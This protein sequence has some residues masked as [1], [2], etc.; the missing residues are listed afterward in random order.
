[1][2]TGIYLLNMSVSGIKNLEKEIRIDFYGKQVNKNFDPIKNKVKAIYGEN[3]TGKTAIITAVDIV[4]QF[5]INENYLRDSQKQALLTEL[6]NKKTK[7]FYFRCE[8]VV[9]FDTLNIYEYEVGFSFDEKGTVF[10]AS[11]SLKYKTNNSKNASTT[12]FACRQGILEET[13]T[14]DERIIDKTKNLLEKQ[15]ALYLLFS[16]NS[17][18]QESFKDKMII[19][20]PVFF[21]AMMFTYFD[22]EDEHITYYQEVLLEELK[23][24]R[25]PQE[26]LLEAISQSIPTNEEK[27]LIKNYD[28]Y[29]KT[30][31]EKEKFIRLFKPSLKKIDIIKRVDGEAYICRLVLDYGDYAVD[32]EF[33]SNGI[34]HLMDLYDVLRA[35]SRGAIAF[36]DEIDT[37]INDVILSKLIE[38]FKLYGTG[39]LCITSH[40]TEP[41]VVLKDSNKAIDFLTR[42]GRIVSWVKN[43]HYSAENCYR[44]GVIEGL[45]FNIDSVDF[46]SVFGE[47]T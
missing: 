29:E 15:S 28:T 37:N 3:G 13:I 43:G 16:L 23:R 27:V 32:R 42:D 6:I 26:S 46:I 35:A 31:R 25:V 5:I 47:E 44:N 19:I 20:N 9:W 34:K 41:M 40:N 18:N 45:P 36:I 12:V 30:I 14:N 1:M 24:T 7:K 38:Y 21:F 39:Q 2:K 11:E 33:E 4:R 8:F 17:H 10:V 22:R